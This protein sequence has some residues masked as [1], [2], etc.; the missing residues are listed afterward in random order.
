MPVNG[1]L[2]VP[3]AGGN[4]PIPWLANL[5]SSSVGGQPFVHVCRGMKISKDF[6]SLHTWP[7]PF[8]VFK[9]GDRLTEISRGK[10]LDLACV[11]SPSRD[12]LDSFLDT[13]TSPE[14][15]VAFIIGEGTNTSDRD[16]FLNSLIPHYFR[17]AVSSGQ[18]EPRSLAIDLNDIVCS[19]NQ[20]NSEV[21]CFYAR[22]TKSSQILRYFNAGHRAPLLI[23]G[24][25]DQVINLSQG[26]PPFGS[27]RTPRY[28]QGAV[29]LQTGDRLI[30]F[31]EGVAKSWSAEDD[32]MADAE[33]R[34]IMRRWKHERAEGI[35]KYVINE[36]PKAACFGQLE[37][38][39]IAASVPA[40]GP[41]EV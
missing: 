9:T 4:A 6:A 26:G 5:Y 1:V 19:G 12:L 30:A 7:F 28:S 2:P 29:Q 14:G 8:P 39:V 27:Q 21:T 35:A 40:N 15:E 17:A 32:V 23:H 11:S 24:K 18:W 20:A 37:R 31:T 16:L 38:I 10:G 13:I 41:S 3:S 25:S 22:Y 36:A 33:L 34:A